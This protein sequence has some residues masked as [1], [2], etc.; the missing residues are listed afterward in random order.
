M[1]AAS[2]VAA[3]LFAVA[4]LPLASIRAE[5]PGKAE[6][7]ALAKIA[8]EWLD[9]AN[10]CSEHKLP[11]SARAC[12]ERA[13]LADASAAGLAALR[14]AT[15][16]DAADDKDSKELERRLKAAAKK[17]AASWDGLVGAVKPES[18]DAAL[19]AR[20]AGWA[21]EALA[22][23]ADAKRWARFVGF[24]EAS[25]SGALAERS[26][27]LSP[28]DKLV[29]RLQKIA[30]GPAIEKLVLKKAAKHPIRYWFSL[31]KGFE[32][33]KD[34]RWPVVVCV[35]GAGSNFEGMGQ[36][37]R[38]A[39]GDLP[40]IVVSPCTFANTN[41]IVGDAGQVA[42]YAKLYPEDVIQDGDKRRLDWDEE[43]I[44]AILDELATTHD[45]DA[46]AYVTGFSGGGLATYMLLMKH[47]D[48]VAVAAPA[49]GNFRQTEYATALKG[50]AAEADLVVPV[51]IFT[52]EKDE[53]REWTFGK[54]DGSP[55][56]EPQT[57][58]A[59][60]A[61]DELGFKVR[62]RTLVPGLGHSPAIEQVV[63]AFKPY[64]LGQKKRGE[65]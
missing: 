6:K 11:A 48:R 31:P 20:A 1:R 59:V 14:G 62:R 34:K 2:A 41:Q 24:A 13:A 38:G 15:G 5:E 54:K 26:M 36:G 30:D 4:V 43:G 22:L 33:K 18:A 51:L 44:L 29:P 32:R 40:Y 55:G 49:C 56:I 46:R 10:W 19:L 9:L 37:Y 65:L 3:A 17:V 39:R 53:H 28:P 25:K 8:K 63:A 61:L 52:G 7:Q 42:K 45:A 57:D 47:P 60:K 16:D 27:Q 23:E 50:K 58:W 21:Y 35:D 12:A 64:M